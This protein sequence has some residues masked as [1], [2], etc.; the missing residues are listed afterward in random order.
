[1]SSREVIKKLKE[2]GWFLVRITGDHHHFKH[3]TKKGTVTVPHPNKDLPKGTLT[4]I[5][6]QAGWK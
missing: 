5:Y 6:R 3:S 4:S 2:D 1:M